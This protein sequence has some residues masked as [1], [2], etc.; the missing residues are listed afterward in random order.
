MLILQ[1]HKKS[2][3]LC[4]LTQ[5]KL[6]LHQVKFYSGNRLDMLVQL[7]NIIFVYLPQR[8]NLQKTK[9]N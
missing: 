5:T 4:C 9:H 7:L 6:F 8:D 3:A 1:E 2:Y